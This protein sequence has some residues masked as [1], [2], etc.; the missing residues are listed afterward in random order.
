[1]G[2]GHPLASLGN[3]IMMMMI[4][5]GHPLASF[6]KDVMMMM[7]SDDHKQLLGMQLLLLLFDSWHALEMSFIT[8]QWEQELKNN[9]YSKLLQS[10]L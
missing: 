2:S 6:K 4:V 8:L 5:D 9:F 3:T 10:K 7:R 1:M